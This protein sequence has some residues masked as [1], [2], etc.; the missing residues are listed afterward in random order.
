MYDNNINNNITYTRYI[1]VLFIL[2]IR[3]ILIIYNKLPSKYNLKCI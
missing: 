3:F 2:S 1:F